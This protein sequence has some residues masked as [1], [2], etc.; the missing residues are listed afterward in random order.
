VIYRLGGYYEQS[1]A[2]PTP[3]RSIESYG[4]TAGLSF[5]T[6]AFGTRVDLTI[7]A[8]V[9]G[10]QQRSLVRDLFLTTTLTLNVGERWFQERKLR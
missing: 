2:T 7:D 8:G 6:G 5:P 9:R 1:Y 3:S 10:T 4:V